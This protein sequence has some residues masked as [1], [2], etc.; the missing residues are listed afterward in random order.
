MIGLPPE[1]SETDRKLTQEEWMEIVKHPKLGLK[2]IENMTTFPQEV[3]D[4]ILQHHENYGGTGY[5]LG[6]KGSQI[7]Y[8]ARVI[9]IADSFSALTTRRGGRQTF[10]PDQALDILISENR[11]YDPKL[12]KVLASLLRPQ[13]SNAA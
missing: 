4:I 12:I 11:K 8:P 5:P 9:A 10:S 13:K 7:Y 6:L 3:K 2:L 1:L